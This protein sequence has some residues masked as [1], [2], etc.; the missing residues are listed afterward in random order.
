MARREPAISTGKLVVNWPQMVGATMIQPQFSFRRTAG[1]QFVVHR[2]SSS[3]SPANFL[4]V[5]VSEMACMLSCWATS[6]IWN[7]RCVLP[8][9]TCCAVPPEC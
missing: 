3:Q 7:L 9:T 6:Q 8:A 5:Y 4:A 2:K 1:G